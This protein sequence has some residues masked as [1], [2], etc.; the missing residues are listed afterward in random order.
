M[1]KEKLSLK[2]LSLLLFGA[3]VFFHPSCKTVPPISSPVTLPLLNGVISP[4]K[5]VSS[6]P[7]WCNQLL[8]IQDVAFVWEG[9]TTNTQ[10]LLNYL[11][12]FESTGLYACPEEIKKETVRILAEGLVYGWET[13]IFDA[14]LYLKSMMCCGGLSEYVAYADN[15]K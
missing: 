12:I 15:F 9:D 5:G 2:I 11:N 10:V 8:Y 3:V 6:M 4:E 1:R 7:S 13:S 14:D